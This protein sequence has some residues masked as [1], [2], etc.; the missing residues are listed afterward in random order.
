[1]RAIVAGKPAVGERMAPEGWQEFSDFALHQIIDDLWQ[2]GETGVLN[3]EFDGLEKVLYLR[4]GIVV[5]A[6]SNDPEEKLPRILIDQGRFSEDQYQAA[7]ANFKE[8]LSVGRNLVEM[9]L[10]SQQE[11]VAGAKAQ[12]FT[13]FAHTLNASSGRYSFKPGDLPK[14]VVNLPLQFPRDF[15]RGLMGLE[16]KAWISS[17]FDNRLDSVLQ[18]NLDRPI[19]FGKLGLDDYAGAIYDLIDGER[20]FNHLVFEA[21]VD[22]FTLFKFLYALSLLGHIAIRNDPVEAALQEDDL[23]DESDPEVGDVLGALD[24]ALAQKDQLD[25]IT[26][27]IEDATPQDL[28][29]QEDPLPV[30]DETVALPKDLLSEAAPSSEQEMP[31]LEETTEIHQSALGFDAPGSDEQLATDTEDTSWEDPEDQEPLHEPAPEPSVMDE[32]TSMDD[33]SALSDDM[34]DKELTKEESLL[35]DEVGS[36]LYQTEPDTRNRRLLMIAGGVIL[37]GVVFLGWPYLSGLLLQSEANPALPE[38]EQELALVDQALETTPQDPPAEDQTDE[39]VPPP[40]TEDESPSTRPSDPIEE[41]PPEDTQP[42][43][44]R[45]MTPE[46]RGFLSPIA[47]G[48]APSRETAG[49]PQ[50]AGQPNRKREERA[51]IVTKPTGDSLPMTELS[52]VPAVENSGENGAESEAAKTER[53]P[54]TNDG[55]DSGGPA[56]SALVERETITR[57]VTSEGAANTLAQ[58]AKT[59]LDSGNFAEASRLFRTLKTQDQEKFTIGIGMLCDEAKIRAKLERFAEESQLFIMSRRY[60]GQ[61]CYWLWWGTFDEKPGQ[62]QIDQ[63][64]AWLKEDHQPAGYSMRFAL[65]Q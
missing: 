15:I 27:P 32:E 52:P 60:Q 50:G 58:D 34:L 20:D 3:T 16:D 51:P 7:K 29:T 13:T 39:V 24:E 26:K 14:G 4:D 35:Q 10:I 55:G 47:D 6:T 48:M 33:L 28:P 53:Q 57:P 36:G 41:A 63:L 11:L 49:E 59:A 19:D 8:D 42:A 37:I 5:F 12:V 61:D 30:M 25:E 31:G 54:V 9:G 65:K 1:M 17:Q 18:K 38:P 43:A 64:P 21:G 46:E 23:D 44:E 22:E 62:D 56:E 40:P 2:S 45:R